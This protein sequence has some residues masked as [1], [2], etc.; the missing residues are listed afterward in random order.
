MFSSG[1]DPSFSQHKKNEVCH[2]D[3][4]FSFISS[5]YFS[6]RCVCY[7]SLPLRCKC[8]TFDTKCNIRFSVLQSHKLTLRLC[9]QAIYPYLFRNTKKTKCV[10]STADFRYQFCL[11]FL[12]FCLLFFVLFVCKCYTFDTK[13]N[14][15]FSVLNV[16]KRLTHLCLS[17]VYTPP[18]TIF[19]KKKCDTFAIDVWS[20]EL[21]T[22]PLSS[23]KCFGSL[24]C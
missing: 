7:F 16:P 14:I 22:V 6:Y 21:Q 20:G 9:F 1:F 5:A 18:W 24:L 23:E 2:F 11:L 8:Y 10:I 13:C 15:W 4:R 19:K 3:H 12:S 17:A